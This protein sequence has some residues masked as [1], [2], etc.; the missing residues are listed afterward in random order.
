M[1][2]TSGWVKIH[3]KLNN[4][5]WRDKP[6]TFCLF[7][8]LLLNANRKDGNWRGVTIPQGSFLTGRKKL[9]QITGLSEREVRTSLN[10]LISTNE[11]TIKT[12]KEYS[13][14]SITNWNCYQ[15]SDQQNAN[16]RP[17][18]DQQND[19]KQE[20]N[21]LKNIKKK[22]Y[23]G[24]PEG[25]SVS[26]WDD[27]KTLR[28][29]KRAPITETVIRDLAREAGRACMTIEQALE[30]SISRNW[31]SF[32]ADWVKTPSPVAKGKDLITKQLEEI[33]SDGWD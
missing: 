26:V 24:P 11:V 21:K 23:T 22:E 10:H 25:V 29:A 3:R 4:W 6:N 1:Q 2:D 18:T 15:Q 32:K 5:E 9:S 17:T 31:Q 7:I 16:Q 20:D 33:H 14:I 13:I 27:Y 12:T 30:Y 28:K 8:H 19:H